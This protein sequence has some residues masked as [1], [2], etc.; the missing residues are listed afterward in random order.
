MKS[1]SLEIQ[2]Y[3]DAHKTASFTS[4]EVLI[5]DISEAIIEEL[6][7]NTS[8]EIIDKIRNQPAALN[9]DTRR[10]FLAIESRIN[11]FFTS[12]RPDLKHEQPDSRLVIDLESM[13]T[14]P[15]TEHQ[16]Q[17]FGGSWLFTW[18]SENILTS[19]G[20]NNSRGDVNA[21]MVEK[22][23]YSLYQYDFVVLTGDEIESA[24][25]GGLSKVLTGLI[26]PQMDRRTS[27]N[28]FTVYPAAL[29]R[30]ADGTSGIIFKTRLLS[31]LT[32]KS[33]MLLQ[34]ILRYMSRGTTAQLTHRKW[35][36]L[37]YTGKKSLDEIA[38]SKFKRDDIKRH[39]PVIEKTFEIKL[40]LV[41][42]STKTNNKGLAWIVIDTRNTPFIK[43]ENRMVLDN[44]TSIINLDREDYFNM[45]D[46]LRNGSCAPSTLTRAKRAKVFD[47]SE[48]DSKLVSSIRDK[49]ESANEIT[50]SQWKEFYQNTTKRFD[51]HYEGKKY[52]DKKWAFLLEEYIAKGWR[53]NSEKYLRVSFKSAVQELL[54]TRAIER[55]V[56]ES[57]LL[58]TID[59]MKLEDKAKKDLLS[60]A[61]T[62]LMSEASHHYAGKYN[63]VEAWEGKAFSWLS[64]NNYFLS[65]LNNYLGKNITMQLI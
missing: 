57:V 61:T 51:I 17:T 46:K 19:S 14:L 21:S 54:V 45:D 20:F 8:K 11:W 18:A 41:E 43:F 6:S 56:Y 49:C 28:F 65:C 63:S 60:Q 59:F 12:A 22:C 48:V 33:L 44:N 47:S 64:K 24:A 26:T 62:I 13:T 42:G 27:S 40:T 35:S 58:S 1:N 31:K 37:L 4:N 36:M 15:A 9:T 3:N 38:W 25:I 16:S 7:K 23:L 5:Y 34:L 55:L 10:V 53:M 29:R 39:F 2:Q 50:E 30:I 32:D 52:T